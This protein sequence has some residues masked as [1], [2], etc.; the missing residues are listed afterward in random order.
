MKK[1]LRT[2][3]DVVSPTIVMA[4]FYIT[5]RRMAFPYERHAIAVALWQ[6]GMVL[7]TAFSIIWILYRFLCRNGA[8][9]TLE[10]INRFAGRPG[11]LLVAVP[12]LTLAMIGVLKLISILIR[13]M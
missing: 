13:G 5:A 2:T 9:Q 10:R 4:F 7:P 6:L 8:A 12:L 1:V 3:F 11:Q